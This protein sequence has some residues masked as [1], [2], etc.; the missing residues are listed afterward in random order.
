MFLEQVEIE[1]CKSLAHAEIDFC[2]TNG[3][4]RK[5][6]ILVGENGTGKSTIL[7]AIGLLLGGSDC[8]PH[9][10]G[11]P[12]QWVRNGAAFC[13]LKATLRTA[14]GDHR[15]IELSFGPE[16]APRE[17]LARNASGLEAIDS[18]LDH[19]KQNYFVAAYGPY[20]RIADATSS[21][22][23]AT[24]QL[25]GGGVGD[26]VGSLITMFDRNAPVNPLPTWAMEL[27]YER[28]ENGLAIVRDAMEALLPGLKFVGIDRRQKR[29]MFGTEDGEVPLEELSDGYQNVAA[30]IGDLLHRVTRAFAHYK[31]PLHARGVL[32][33]DEVDA[34]LH[35]TWQRLLRTY[36]ESR[37]PNFQIVATTHS[38]LTL[39]QFHEEE[40]YTLS[41]DMERRVKLAPFPA[42]PSKLRLH[43]LY[44]LAFKV[45]SFD[46]VEVE[47]SKTTV[48]ALRDKAKLQPAE[49]ARLAEAKIVLDDA[50]ELRTPADDA[51]GNEALESL[52]G[53]LDKLAA[54]IEAKTGPNGR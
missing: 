4:I 54:D 3:D 33:I 23:H 40:A 8:L 2:K 32:L 31:K 38:A 17:I 29:L 45:N 28:G 35:P 37:L 15:K 21:F 1:N 51:L 42:D 26:R 27:E 50:A 16:Q 39:Q 48:A 30:W 7:K 19:A 25:S 9:I 47:R 18:A 5:W 43:Q 13:R 22:A 41:R 12:A 14:K 44:D 20:R 36:L 24:P 46:S 10:I 53:R 6:S 34:H 49:A 52:F 11:D